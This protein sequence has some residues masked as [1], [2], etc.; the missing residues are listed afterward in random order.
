M[1]ERPSLVG[2]CLY[3]YGCTTHG[4][5]DKVAKE[6]KGGWIQ[7]NLARQLKSDEIMAKDMAVGFG[8]GKSWQNY[9][10]VRS[11]V[12]ALSVFALV[13]CPGA[14]D[15]TAEATVLK[16]GVRAKDRSGLRLIRPPKPGQK[17]FVRRF[18]PT[19]PVAQP[20]RQAD[21]RWFWEEV[22]ALAAA[23]AGRWGE[24]LAL[25]TRRGAAEGALHSPGRI[26]QIAERWRP[27]IAKAARDQDVSEALLLAVIAVE[28]NGQVGARSPKGAQ[29]LMQL[30]PA[31]A[32]R[33]GVRDA[34]DPQQNIA[35]GAAYLNWLLDRFS[36]DPVLALA[37]YNAGEGAVGRHGGVPP[38]AE[39]RDYVVKVFDALVAAR[40]L[41]A[42]LDGGPRTSCAWTALAAAEG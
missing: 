13:G 23:D 11:I 39:T 18:A 24:G 20:R 3:A 22:D 14:G 27:L 34:Y 40:A 21:H 8:M 17:R 15:S 9:G 35:G 31:T 1:R 42:T 7:L 38:Y 26:A 25:L 2:H 4:G 36:G 41:C 19:A 28:S 5:A 37:G 33:F 16:N 12:V 6:A 10:A 32:D 29:G 30:I